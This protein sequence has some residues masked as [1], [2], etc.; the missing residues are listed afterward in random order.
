[1]H[2]KANPQL[3]VDFNEFTLVPRL[4]EQDHSDSTC[5]TQTYDIKPM[6]GFDNWIPLE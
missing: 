3:G 1:M 4:L 5:K 6:V 2:N